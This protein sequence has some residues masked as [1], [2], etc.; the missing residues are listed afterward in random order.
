ML[1]AKDVAQPT[2]FEKKNNTFSGGRYPS[3]AIWGFA[4]A[5]AEE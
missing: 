2:R 3:S 1:I 5:L 4:P